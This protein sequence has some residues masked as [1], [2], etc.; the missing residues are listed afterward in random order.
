MQVLFNVKFE[1]D[2][3]RLESNNWGKEVLYC[4]DKLILKTRN[5]RFQNKYKIDCPINGP[6]E[7]SFKMDAEK[8]Y[9]VNVKFQKEDKVLLEHNETIEHLMPNWG[10]EL[11]E[12]DKNIDKIDDKEETAEAPVNTRKKVVKSI[13]SM[14]IAI[15]VWGLMFSYEYALLLVLILFI[16]E[17]GH[18]LAMKIFK[19]KNTSITFIPPF[20]AAAYGIKKNASGFEELTV[21][22]AGPI[23]G[24]IIGYALFY[25][26]ISFLS[27][28]V[29]KMLAV[30]FIFLNYLNLLPI[31]P[32]DGG[33]IVE[34]TFLH[35]NPKLQIILAAVGALLVGVWGIATRSFLRTFIAIVFAFL[36]YGRVVELKKQ[37]NEKIDLKKISPML[38]TM[39]GMVYILLFVILYLFMS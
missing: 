17:L 2:I 10:K 3:Y 16:H 30:Q 11:S 6:I 19:Y 38:R 1:N 23:P 14:V 28:D 20:G 15:I 7:L 37:Q 18:F 29:Y 4:N 27:E 22:L 35:K 25:S 8:T 26:N 36:F 12:Y 32:L 39:V 31:S 9:T 5:F 34:M 13:I 21:L 33:R 24:I